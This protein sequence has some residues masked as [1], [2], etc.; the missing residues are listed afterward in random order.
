M[1]VAAMQDE[2]VSHTVKEEHEAEVNRINE[3]KSRNEVG[4]RR[5][6]RIE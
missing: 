3:E 1:I 4:Q 5:A 2:F 6:F